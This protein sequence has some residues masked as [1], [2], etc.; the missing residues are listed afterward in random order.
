MK[1]QMTELG[2]MFGSLAI[3]LPVEKQSN[4]HA[5][6]KRHESGDDTCSPLPGFARFSMNSASFAP[7][8]RSPKTRRLRRP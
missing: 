2:A 3:K 1:V 8:F 4:C 6:T 7:H 5:Q